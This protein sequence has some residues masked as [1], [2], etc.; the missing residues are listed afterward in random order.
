MFDKMKQ[1]GQLAKMANDAKKLQKEV[2][3][4]E[5]TVEESGIK[6][7]INGAMKIVEFEVNGVSNPTVINVLNKAVEKSQKAMAE[8][9]RS[10][11]GLGDMMKNMMG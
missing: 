10:M 5:I 8:K 1:M 9:L 4:E 6:V 3:K 11:P 2:E 7:T